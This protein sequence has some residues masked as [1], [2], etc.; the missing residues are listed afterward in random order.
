MNA[1]HSAA[2]VEHYTPPAIVDAA[3]RVL[4]GDIDLDPASSKIANRIVRARKIFTKEQNGFTRQWEGRVFL[5]PPGGLCDQQGRMLPP[6]QR[7][8]KQPPGT[9]EGAQ[10]SAA[11][12]HDRLCEQIASGD[13]T[14][15]V[16]I[17][18]SVE[19]VQTTQ[20]ESRSPI[21]NADALCFP[22]ERIRFVVLDPAGNVFLPQT[23]P[24]HANVIA[25]YGPRPRH[26]RH[27]FRAFGKVVQ[28]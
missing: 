1:K 11:A 21:L 26:F 23:S 17:G 24:T 8:V 13:V 4:G 27:E 2:S 3:R 14:D 28:R 12:W 19:L 9:Y 6:R 15:A 20:V 25:Y 16:F 5:N 7:G 18:F 22:R 10:S